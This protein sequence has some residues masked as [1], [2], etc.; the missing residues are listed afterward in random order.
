MVEEREEDP[1][2]DT[3]R[4]PGG[5]SIWKLLIL[6]QSAAKPEKKQQKNQ[7]WEKK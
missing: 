4:E 7:T 3:E 6:K 5:K 2:A 1:G